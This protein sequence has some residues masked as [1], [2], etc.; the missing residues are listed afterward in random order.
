M[1]W[2]AVVVKVDSAQR[3]SGLPKPGRT[4]GRSYPSQVVHIPCHLVPSVLR[5]GWEGEGRMRSALGDK[6]DVWGVG[7]GLTLIS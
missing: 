4:H 5:R 6:R 7:M 1:R 2:A 3:V